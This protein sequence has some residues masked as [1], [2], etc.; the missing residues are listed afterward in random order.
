MREWVCVWPGDASACEGYLS[1]AR[2]FVA[3]EARRKR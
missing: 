1:E 3:A 2:D